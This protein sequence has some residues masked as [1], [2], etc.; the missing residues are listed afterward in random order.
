MEIIVI[1]KDKLKMGLKTDM[2]NMS[3]WMV[4]FIKDY[5]KTEK[6]MAKEN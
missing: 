1:M 5:G 6:G 2:E 3:I 4:R